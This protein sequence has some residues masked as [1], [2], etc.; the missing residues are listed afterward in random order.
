MKPCLGFYKHLHQQSLAMPS[1]LTGMSHMVALG[2]ISRFPVGGRSLIGATRPP[3]PKKEKEVEEGP[4]EQKTFKQMTLAE[5]KKLFVQQKGKS[6]VDYLQMRI[7]AGNGGNGCLSFRREKFVP[8]GG[9]D[10]GNGG[11]GGSIVL[12]ADEGLSS[13]R[14]V[15]RHYKGHDGSNGKGAACHGR[16]GADTDIRV[17]VGTVVRERE[18]GVVVDMTSHGQRFT[19]AKGGRGGW[20]NLHF[21]SKLD[22]APKRATPGLPGEERFLEMELKT[23]ADVG[24]V[25]LPNAGKSSFLAAVTNAHPAIADYPF[26]TLNPHLGV[27]DFPDHYCLTLADIPG[28]IRGGH[29]NLGL[30]HSFL[31]HIERSRVLLYV[32]DAAAS[33][34]ATEDSAEN[35]ESLQADDGNSGDLGVLRGI[36]RTPWD[37]LKDLQNELDMYLPG[38]TKRPSLVVA[39]KIDLPEAEENLNILRTKTPLP[40]VGVSALERRNISEATSMIRKLVE[41]IKS[42]GGS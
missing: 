6:F 36:H 38:M 18:G 42:Q 26:T 14:G 3:A 30:G 40:V 31:R 11:T 20:G 24:L 12:V 29:R 34:L 1:L 28:L 33:P 15:E 21:K 32:V 5:R 35:S 39:N 9:P 22:T 23:I 17:P 10:G 16:A 19:V 2:R 41:S 13:L 8:R 27:L 4:P 37:D 7:V 25:G